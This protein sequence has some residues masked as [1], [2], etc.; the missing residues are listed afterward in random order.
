MVY[1]MILKKK[2]KSIVLKFAPIE[3]RLWFHRIK[4]RKKD[5]NS[6]LANAPRF[7]I[8]QATILNT[9]VDLPDA[10]S[11]C[12]MYEEIFKKEIYKFNTSTLKPYIID[13][14]ANIG[15]S[16]IY[17]NNLFNEAEIVAFEPDPNVFKI[18]ESNVAK[19]KFKNIKLE[20]AGLWG[21]ETDLIFYQEGADGGALKAASGKNTHLQIKVKTKLLSNYIDRKVNFLKLDIEGAEMEVIKE[22]QNK[23]HFVD[24]IFVEYHSF[25]DTDQEIH[26]LLRILSNAGFRLHINTPGLS[27]IQPFMYVNTYNNMDMQLNIYGV[28]PNIK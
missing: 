3:L 25:I 17:F 24:R 22:I 12:F 14:G 16:S 4:S 15:L 27:S 21:S 7:T 23:L 10:A 2:V 1:F 19:F 26:E 9:V 28:K 20:N 6:H 18:L 13:G 5:Q 11:F 8:Q